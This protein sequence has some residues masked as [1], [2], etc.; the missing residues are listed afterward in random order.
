MSRGIRAVSFDAMNTLIHPKL[1]IELTY[2]RQLKESAGLHVPIDLLSLQ[3]RQAF[4]QE[5]VAHP[6]YGLKTISSEIWWSN[7]VK[8]TCQGALKQM[9]MENFISRDQLDEIARSLFTEFSHKSAWTLTQH[10]EMVLET[11][12]QRNIQPC[13]VSNFDSRLRLILKEFTLLKHFEPFVVLSGEVGVEKPNMKIFMLLQNQLSCQ[14]QQI[15]HIGDD[16][17]RDFKAA[18]SVGFQAV[19]FSDR[20]KCLKIGLDDNACLSSLS[21]ILNRV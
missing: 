1:P 3:F 7:V 17:D 12:K 11:L 4:A 6:S 15:L 5:S 8:N 18:K 21:E 10:A 9:K 19:L 14:A 16:F 13:I 2:A 20:E